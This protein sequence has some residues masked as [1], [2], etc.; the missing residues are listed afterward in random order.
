MTT[1]DTRRTAEE[2]A[3]ARVVD[4]S[5]LAAVLFGE[6]EA[7]AIAHRLGHAALVTTPL[8]RFEITN[9]CWKKLLRHPEERSALLEALE[10]LDQM[11]LYE[12][13]VRLPEVVLLAEREDLTAYDASY[14]W[15]ARELDVELVTLDDDLSRAAAGSG[16]P[17]DSG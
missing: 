15:L 10:L 2:Q 3:W 1:A 7:D 16:R 12:L 13:E 11:E 6:P 14:L 8:L 9:V 5:A 17:A 4:A